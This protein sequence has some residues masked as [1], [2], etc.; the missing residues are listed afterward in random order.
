MDIHR[1]RERE[2]KQSAANIVNVSG[3]Y[4]RPVVLEDM[5]NVWVT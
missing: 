1:K 5:E 2:R 4:S 3:R